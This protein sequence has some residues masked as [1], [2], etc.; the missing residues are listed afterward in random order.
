MNRKLAVALGIACLVCCAPLL[1]P[2]LGMAGL[3]GVGGRLAG[4]GW[5]EVVCLA[6]LA[7][8]LAGAV[9]FLVRR[10][11]AKAS[12]PYCDVKE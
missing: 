9:I 12:E 1:I 3:A 6:I 8:A 2:L 7:A 10:R 4:L 11:R 5:P